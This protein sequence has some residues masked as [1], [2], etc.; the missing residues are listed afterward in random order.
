MFHLVSKPLRGMD[1]N[2]WNGSGVLSRLNV[3]HRRSTGA[4]DPKTNIYMFIWLLFSKYSEKKTN[5]F[6][7]SLGECTKDRKGIPPP[8]D[9]KD[10][11]KDSKHLKDISE[12]FL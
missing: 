11:L 10:F 5:D 2:M 7:V 8:P 3:R 9:K 6:C 1:H 12:I 4:R